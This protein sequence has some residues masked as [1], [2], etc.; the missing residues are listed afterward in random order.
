MELD[1]DR[2]SMIKHCHQRLIFF[3]LDI[4]SGALCYVHLN[5][6]RLLLLLLVLLL[7]FFF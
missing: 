1:F 7:L 5:P 3:Q 6:A 2:K 4:S